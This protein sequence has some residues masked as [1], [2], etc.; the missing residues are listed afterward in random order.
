MSENNHDIDILLRR[1]VERQLEG[2]DWEGLRRGI[3][4]RLASTDAPFR[5]RSLYGRWAAMAAALV[6]A[7]GVLIYAVICATGPGVNETPGGEAKVAMIDIPR[8]VAT[9]RVSLSP[10]EKPGRCEITMLSSDKPRPEGG[11][12]TSWCIVVRQD[13]PAEKHSRGRDASDV[14]CLF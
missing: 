13:S 5:S 12:Q 11:K 1:N 14:V 3:G 8:A 2:F 7:G 9:A 4:S 10:V 6:L